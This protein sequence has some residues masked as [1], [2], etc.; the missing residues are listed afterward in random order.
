[1]RFLKITFLLLLLS[2]F[3]LSIAQNAIE[4]SLGQ[5]KSGT[6]LSNHL[7]EATISEYNLNA[8][9]PKTITGV[10]IEIFNNTTQKEE[11]V[12]KNHNQ[13]R[14]SFNFKRGNAYTIMLRKEGYMVKRIN[15]KIGIDDCITCFQGLT[16]LTPAK[17]DRPVSL[18]ELNI[19]MRK[20][21]EGDRVVMPE[22]QFSGK[23]SS[24]TAQTEEALKELAIILKD[25]ANIISE[26]EIHTDSRGTTESNLELSHD[27]AK[28]VVTYLITQGV[29][30]RDVFARGYGE[31][32]IINE[33]VDDANCTEQKHNQNNR[34]I[35]KLHT[36]IGENSLFSKSLSTILKIEN[37]DMANVDYQTRQ[38]EKIKNKTGAFDMLVKSDVV[39]NNQK[40][41]TVLA[42]NSKKEKVGEEEIFSSS[43][44][45]NKVSNSMSD[46]PLNSENEAKICVY[47]KYIPFQ[48][49]AIDED[50]GGGIS[51]VKNVVGTVKLANSGEISS[52]GTLVY[53]KDGNR[54]MNRSGRAT[55]VPESFTG[56]KVELFTSIEE[57]PNSHAIFKS[58]GKVFLDDT[59]VNFSYLIGSFVEKRSAEKFLQSAIIARYPEAKI[60]KYKDGKRKE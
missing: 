16:T 41:N 54:V 28:A 57:L 49:Q 40:E 11:L 37:K 58:Y 9:A 59:G 60:I 6:K 34:V 13:A 20:I 2:S 46:T 33:C 22:I 15:A 42:D 38:P 5:E 27:R 7:C 48:N 36:Q 1:M 44:G 23:S 26:I 43:S 14:F 12:L 18:S 29:A 53:D 3:N 30:E 51:Q 52:E 25:N 17:D 10:D 24:L 56:F 31:R 47:N 8:T 4:N 55:L 21:N 35:F 19:E 50:L 39:E 45:L 32:K